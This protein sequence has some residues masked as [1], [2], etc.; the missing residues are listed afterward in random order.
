MDIKRNS[1]IYK[2][3]IFAEFIIEN[4]IIMILYILSLM[5]Q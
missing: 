1:W 3:Y 4:I 5:S 2:I